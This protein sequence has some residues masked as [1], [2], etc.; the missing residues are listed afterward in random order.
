MVRPSN[1]NIFRVTGLCA[2]NSPVTSEFP[3]QR[4]V[5]RSFGVFFDLCLNKR[6]SKQLW[7][8]WF[9]MLS[10][11]LWHHCIESF[12]LLIMWI[13]DVIIFFGT[14]H[15]SLSWNDR[16]NKICIKICIHVSWNKFWIEVSQYIDLPW[17]T[18]LCWLWCLSLTSVKGTIKDPQESVMPLH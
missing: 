15:I 7:G 6:L 3:A 13:G 14:C 11:P 1:G 5:T 9:E 10:C 17:M 18:I 12:M 16:K 2:G 8:W 4:P